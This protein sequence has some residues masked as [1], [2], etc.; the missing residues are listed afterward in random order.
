MTAKSSPRL[1]SDGPSV[2]DT[3]LGAV[4]SVL[5]PAN[6]VVP[7][8]EPEFGG[9]EWDYVKD[10]IDTGWVSSV[11]SYVDRFE[12][13]LGAYT[14]AKHVVAT[15]NGTAALHL[16]LKLVGVEAGD[17][18][19]IPA[20]T[21]VATAN[22]VSYCGAVPHL[23]DVSLPSAG[24]D[25]D[26]LG[27]H[28]DEILETRGERKVNRQT[29][30]PV[31]AVVVMHTFGHPAEIEKL[32]EVCKRHGL[33]LVE[34]A[35]E[36]LGSTWQGRHCGTFGVVASL[37][38]NGNKVVTTGGGGAVMTAD[39]EIGRRAKHLSTTAKVPHAWLYAHDE[40]GYNYRMP[41]LNAALGCAQLE[42][43]EKRVAEKRRLAEAYDAAFASSNDISFLREP[44]GSRSNYWLA[45]ILLDPAEGIEAR[46]AV[47]G[48][49]NGAGY[50]ARPAWALMHKLAPYA[51]C[52][53]AADLSVAETVERSLVN[54]P[55]SPRLGRH[56]T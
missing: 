17:E 28:L 25:P 38:F 54:L 33:P 46:D 10:C 41:N 32:A 39:P 8:H 31:A 40:V 4:A 20:L 6:G 5:G 47:L 13:D 30:R 9:R 34:D 18:V 42:Q 27:R 29:G 37:S 50:M 55:S 48:R 11:G 51:R 21:F 12:R 15:V 2:A 14:G 36:S 35:A 7:L 16:C 52:P 23:V 1:Q 53:R 43:L 19:I 56:L 45:A 49:L 3:V 44:A 26:R 22:A 24:I